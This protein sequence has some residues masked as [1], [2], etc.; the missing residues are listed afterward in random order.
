MLILDGRGNLTDFL[1]SFR[2]ISLYWL[3]IY[4]E[5]KN[6]VLSRMMEMLQTMLLCFELYYYLL[7]HVLLSAAY[8]F[9]NGFLTFDLIYFHCMYAGFAF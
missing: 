2:H 7:V 8:I 1:G 3:D 5:S 6:C 4:E 9:N